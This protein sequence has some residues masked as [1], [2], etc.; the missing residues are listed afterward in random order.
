[1]HKKPPIPQYPKP[2]PGTFWG[3][4]TFFNPA[5]YKNKKQN[6]L[7]FRESSK[8]QGLNLITVELAFNNQPFELTNKD[9]DILVQVRS[10]SIMWQKERL[11]NIGLKHL[12]PN[13][14]KVA[15][16]D[17]D[18]I[19]LNDSWVKE[20]SR[21]LESY[22]IVQPFSTYLR[23][24]KDN[25]VFSSKIL[26]QIP[27]S[28][29]IDMDGK[30]FFGVGYR[31][32]QLGRDILLKKNIHYYG[33]VGLVWASRRSVFEGIGFFDKSVF[34]VVDMLMAHVF[35]NNKIT[36]EG[37]YYIN[38]NT[39][40]H[41]Q[42]WAKKVYPNVRGSVYYTGG[43]VLHLWHGVMRRRNYRICRKILN[44]YNFDP[45][46]DLKVSEDGVF[47]WQDGR[48]KIQKQ[49]KKY[50]KQRNEEGRFFSGAE[51]LAVFENFL[52]SE[53]DWMLGIAGK[54]LKKISPKA[55]L[56]AKKVELF[57]RKSVFS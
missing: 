15:W 6:Y 24:K 56:K 10:N 9:A 50:F 40:K 38:K 25:E 33:Q 29:D 11:L 13:C 53:I 36:K 37:R 2:L 55:Y 28:R 52:S 26:E 27:F 4:T 20:T 41:L 17:S 47:E 3:I 49:V 21:A 45:K 22:A 54:F 32:S 30:R 35:Y 18:I 8:K 46:T 48:E 14:D 12:P 34:P 19:F 23:L 7:K 44:D 31:A 39:K 57:I 51:T 43:E 1:M 16:I 5:G 42:D